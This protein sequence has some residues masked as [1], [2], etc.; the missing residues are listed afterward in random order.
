MVPKLLMKNCAWAGI[1]F[2]TAFLN[3]PSFAQSTA[4]RLSNGWNLN[5]FYADTAIQHTAWKP[6]LYEDTTTASSGHS[7]LYKKFFEEHLVNVQQP[8]FTIYGDIIVDEYIGYNKRPVRVRDSHDDGDYHVPTMNTRGYEVSGSIGKTF[9]FETDFYENQGRFSAYTDSFIRRYKMI[10]RQ[11]RYKNQGDGPGFD[12]NYSNTRL[13][14]TPGRHLLFDLGYSRNFIGDGY[15]SMLLSDY[16][17]DH[18]YFRAALTFG[19]F[20]YTTMWSQYTTNISQDHSLYSYGYP[21]KWGQTYLLDWKATKNFTAG[22]FESV[23][24]AGENATHRNDLSITYASPVIFLHTGQSKSGIKNNELIGLNLK[25]RIFPGIHVYAQAVADELGKNTKNRY[26]AQVGARAADLLKIKGLNALVEFNT[27]RPYTYSADTDQ[28]SYTHSLLPLAHPLGANFNELLGLADYTY[29]N[30]WFRLEGFVAKYG[31][32][33]Q[34]INYGHNVLNT[35][36]NYPSGNITTG[37]GLSTR[38]YYSDLRIAY[39]LNRKSNLRIESGFTYRREI[40]TAKKYEDIIAT[41]GVRMSFRGL[42]YDF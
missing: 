24:W 4:L 41:I 22:L 25:Y 26:A 8:D 10:P 5:R 29:K 37:Q 23:T 15:R 27:A 3:A 35:K 14:Y 34:Q 17:T 19:N 6:L 39:I 11:S 32:D 30:W 18:P 40:T 28:T 42:Y 31:N 7:W 1:F 12:F 16:A 21:H 20:Q 38:L 9:Y 2:F 36:T 33:E 13:I